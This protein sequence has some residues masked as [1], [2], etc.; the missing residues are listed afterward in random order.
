MECPRYPEE[1]SAK[2]I[3]AVGHDISQMRHARQTVSE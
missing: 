2:H 3:L 1:G